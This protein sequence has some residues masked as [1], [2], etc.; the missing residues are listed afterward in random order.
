MPDLRSALSRLPF[1]Y[2][3]KDGTLD[4]WDVK[5]TGDRAADTSTGRSHA[6]LLLH[7]MREYDAG[8]MLFHVDEAITA[9]ATPCEAMVN[10]FVAEISEAIVSSYKKCVPLE[11]VSGFSFAGVPLPEAVGR[12]PFIKVQGDHRV[13]D[14]SVRKGASYED[15]QA[16]GR[17]YGALIAKFIRDTNAPGFL[18]NLR[19][20]MM[21]TVGFT[22]PGGALRLGLLSVLAEIAMSG[23]RAGTTH[24]RAMLVFHEARDRTGAST[25]L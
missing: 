24:Q 2:V 4:L 19:E 8:H 16:R 18:A 15:L 25:V 23:P 13:C 11:M 5:P 9:K 1:V 20:S 12:L 3:K 10:G 6:A 14:F 7:V 17:H 22:E 21:L